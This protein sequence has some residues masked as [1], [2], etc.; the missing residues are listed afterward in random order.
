M[1]YIK[2]CTWRLNEKFLQHF[3]FLCKSFSFNINIHRWRSYMNDSLMINRS[4]CLFVSMSVTPNQCLHQCRSM[5][6]YYFP[7]TKMWKGFHFWYLFRSLNRFM[8]TLNFYIASITRLLNQIDLVV[9]CDLTMPPHMF[10]I[11]N[12]HFKNM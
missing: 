12:V 8:K 2:A 9:I 11:C 6:T 7:C 1:Y 3:S 4:V 5:C 10:M